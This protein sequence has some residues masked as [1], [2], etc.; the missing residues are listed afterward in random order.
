MVARRLI[1]RGVRFVQVY[2]GDTN[3]WDAHQLGRRVRKDADE[4]VR[5]GSRSQSLGYTLWM[6]GGGVKAGIGYGATD[7][8]GLRAVGK[9]VHIRNFHATI[10]HLLGLDHEGFAFPHDGLDE[11]LIG[12]TDDVEIVSKILA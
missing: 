4:R 2:A 11:R 12:P 1:E 10:L 5:N 9:P 6:A 7:E 3:G 8:V